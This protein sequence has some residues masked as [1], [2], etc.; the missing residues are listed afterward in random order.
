MALRWR[1]LIEPHSEAV[2]IIN[3]TG[4]AGVAGRWSASGSSQA[5]VSPNQ[6]IRLAA[7]STVRRG[8]F[9]I[10]HTPPRG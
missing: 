1:R 7:C 4:L 3:P 9:A 5:M 8:V 10:P 6:T 2:V